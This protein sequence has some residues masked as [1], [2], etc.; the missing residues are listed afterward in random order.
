MIGDF[1][2]LLLLAVKF[3]EN[4]NFLERCQGVNRQL[5]LDMTYS[6]YD[7]M[8]VQRE[9][10]KRKNMGSHSAAPVVFTST[11]GVTDLDQTKSLGNLVY[12]I[13]QTPQIWLDHQTREEDGE[14][15]LQWEVVEGLFSEETLQTMFDRYKEN[16]L[17][18]SNDAAWMEAREIDSEYMEGV[19]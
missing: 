7:G 12:N 18:L 1:T 9:I 2:S 4:Q 3:E 13:T 6:I 16:I 15:L 17:K 14:L 10:A 5:A 8:Q 19:L 11:L